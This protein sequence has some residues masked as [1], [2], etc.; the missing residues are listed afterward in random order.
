MKSSS[1]KTVEFDIKTPVSPLDLLRSLWYNID[2]KERDTM[3]RYFN[4][5]ANCRPKEHY[6]VDLTSRLEEI[7]QMIDKGQYFTI[8]KGRQF[9]KTTT[10]RALEN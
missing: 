2:S 8:N 10:L 9:G 6:M 7:K 4:I 3:Q 1:V 5:T